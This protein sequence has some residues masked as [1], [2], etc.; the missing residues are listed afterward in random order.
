MEALESFLRE[1]NI[2]EIES[3]IPDMT[4]NARG[5]FYPTRKFLAE[6][7]GRIPEAILVQT[8]TGDWADNHD[9]L[10][11]T[12][13]RDMILVPDLS[14]LRLVPWADEPTAQ[15]IND[16]YDAEGNVHPLSTRGI[17][18]RVL[19]LYKE[20]GLSPIIAP[21]VEFYLL[22]RNL[23]PDYELKSA[24]GRSGRR[25]TARQSYSIDAV[26]EFNPI[27]DTLYSYC[28]TQG[29]DVDTLIHESGA[30][31]M[32]INFLH[33][34]PMNLADQVFAFK[35]TL[36]E[37]ALKHDIYAT[38]MAK[39]M[40]HE[41]GS[42][43]HIHQSLIDNKT[44]NNVFAGENGN[45]SKTFYHFMGGLQRY[46]PYAI[47]FFAPNVNSY[48]RFVPDISAPVNM[49]WGIDNRTTGLRSPASDPAATRIENRFPGADSNPYLAIA[50]SLACGY[51]GMK[52]KIEPLAPVEGM[53]FSP[54]D[55]I[56]VARTLVEGLQLLD[57]CEPL[58]DILGERFVKAY[59]G[60]K[61][62]EFETFNQVI[63]S[64]EREHLLLNV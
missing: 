47:S 40:E 49:H 9:E 32:E 62:A 33:G 46:V 10:V 1:N 48:R 13:D 55:K 64:W 6:E 39:P 56:E 22:Q 50:L 60:V 45:Y 58:K 54:G 35:R 30:A 28:D 53:S 21:E 59:I 5:K 16:C 3:T 12:S 36:R 17:L 34:D 25:E 29:L 57:E 41:P 51:L 38:F 20:A 19:N 11:H 26:N 52:E 61:T 4:G 24:I 14:T 15:I 44:G 2:T 7:S 43:M 27:I 42:S 31:Q 37:T 63:S 18:R 8:V 23:D